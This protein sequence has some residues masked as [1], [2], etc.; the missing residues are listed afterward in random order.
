LAIQTA[1]W[2]RARGLG[3]DEHSRGSLNDDTTII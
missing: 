2:Q 1:P 3:H